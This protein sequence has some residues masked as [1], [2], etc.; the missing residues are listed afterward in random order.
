MKTGGSI[1]QTF[2]GQKISRRAFLEA[3]VAGI[4]ALIAGYG[5]G[6]LISSEPAWSYAIHGFLP[7]DEQI[8]RQVVSAF[9]ATA[10]VRGY[11][12]QIKA[13][14]VWSTVIADACA[15]CS[16]KPQWG[17]SAGTLLVRMAAINSPVQADILVSDEL[18]AIYDPNREF[19][20]ALLRLRTR[21]Q[22]HKADFLFSMV[23]TRR[24]FLGALLDANDKVAV[25]RDETGLLDK[26]RL[27]QTFKD[28]WIRG[29]LGKTGVTIENGQVWVHTATCRNQI[30]RHTGF[31]SQVNEVI[32][33]APNK[34]MIQIETA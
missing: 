30:C 11:P 24:S 14:P 7:A 25:I 12:R 5:S 26:I 9:Y 3:S 20:D 22:T 1:G 34:I 18:N 29:P 8:V 23:Y 28:I 32:A 4:T 31:A 13:D 19:D 27:S 17:G 21:L 15:S 2:L 16:R 33:C 6:R 10:D